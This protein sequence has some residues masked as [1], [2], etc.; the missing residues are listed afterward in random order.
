[1]SSRGA[2]RRGDL[3]KMP[4]KVL[5]FT[6]TCLRLPQ[7]VLDFAMTVLL[8]CTIPLFSVMKLLFCSVCYS[9]PFCCAFA[10]MTAYRSLQ[11][12]L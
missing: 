4:V 8:V 6:G 5:L 1:M 12:S 9:F 7:P 11:N 2:K 3:P 10:R